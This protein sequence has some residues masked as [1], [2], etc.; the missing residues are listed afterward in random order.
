VVIT[1]GDVYGI[2][3]RR[4]ELLT[5]FADVQR[6]ARDSPGCLRYAFAEATGE[7]D[8]FVLLGQ[9]RDRTSLDA[10]YASP[11]FA[12]YQTA[13]HGLLARPSELSIFTV[14]AAEHPA[15]PAAMDPRDAD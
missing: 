15:A 10:H 5:A 8:H 2:A 13:L 11:A 12:R 9:W 1:I 3:G 4:R 14:E 7:P 6:A